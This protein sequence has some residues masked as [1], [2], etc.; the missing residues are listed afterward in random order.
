MISVRS[1]NHIIM[2]YHYDH[3]YY[4]HYSAVLALPLIRGVLGAAKGDGVFV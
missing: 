1:T 2:C 4:H 3:Y